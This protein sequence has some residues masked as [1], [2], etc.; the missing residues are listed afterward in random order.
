MALD[1]YSD[2]ERLGLA[3]YWADDAATKLAAAAG[4]VHGT[5]RE[6]EDILGTL[7]DGLQV[8]AE[9]LGAL[10]LPFPPTTMFGSNVWQ[11]FV[12]DGG[13]KSPQVAQEREGPPKT[14][15][16]RKRS[17][18]ASGPGSVKKQ[19]LPFDDP[20]TDIFA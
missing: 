11:L 7:Y 6:G 20:L 10:T 16:T 17:K 4:V 1:Q 12:Q 5:S 18:A 13:E 8:L 2:N 9:N 14:K 3:A 15:S 19:P